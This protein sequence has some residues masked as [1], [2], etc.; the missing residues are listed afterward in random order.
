MP[1]DKVLVT[2]TGQMPYSYEAVVTYEGK[3]PI[4]IPQ[5]RFTSPEPS[6]PTR[7]V[8]DVVSIHHLTLKKAEDSLTRVFARYFKEAK[9][10]LT[11]TALRSI[12]VFV[13]GEVQNPGA[14]NASPIERVST[15]ITRAGNLTP[16]GSKRNIKLIRS[17]TIITVDLEKFETEGDIATN[18]FLESGDHIHIPTRIGSVI[19]KGAVFG[20]GEYRIRY[21]VL[22]AERERVSEGIY[23]ILPGERVSN[24]IKRAGGIAPWA[25]LEAGYLER[26]E[27]KTKEK[28][29]IPLKLSEILE[30]KNSPE[31]IE[32]WDG[33]VIVIP[34]IKSEVYVQGEVN[35]PGSYLFFPNHRALDYIGKAGGFTIFANR[36]RAYL[37][38]GDKKIPLR[39]DPLIEP[40]DKIFVPRITFK[41]WQDYATILGAISPFFAGAI[42]SLIAR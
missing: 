15:I 32:L 12:V 4:Q 21:A 39:D 3:L 19:V 41:W 33:D 30:V 25:D 5:L 35:S 27:K 11:L 37:Q 22:T 28:V 20:R 38:R 7:E 8:V 10:K 18:P 24:L 16:L 14:Y 2:I 6:F 13:T 1:G 17:D 40:G 26:I 31:D 9:V 42:V 36:K 23:E 34:S 29:K